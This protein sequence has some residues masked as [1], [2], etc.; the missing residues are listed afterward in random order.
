MKKMLARLRRRPKTADDQ[1]SSSETDVQRRERWCRLRDHLR[2][3]GLKDVPDD[4]LEEP[5]WHTR[6][7]VPLVA[8]FPKVR[9]AADGR[10][11]L[12]P[13]LSTSVAL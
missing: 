1:D 8:Y 9:Q 7:G 12:I 6:P 5:E 2:D 11:A 13:T 4:C 10:A 3:R